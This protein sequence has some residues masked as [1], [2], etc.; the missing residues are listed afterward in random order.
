MPAH[1][2]TAR[3]IFLALIAAAV[4]AAPAAGRPAR[5]GAVPGQLVF[6]IVGKVSYSDDFGDARWQGGHEGNDI[7]AERKAPVVAV[8]AGR[9]AFW[10]RSSSA[11]C[12]L[13]L[14]GRS[15][16]MLPLHPPEQRPDDAERQPRLVRPRRLVRARP[17]RRAER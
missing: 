11:G 10:T 14:Y 17:R 9:V 2:L 4:L 8:E 3:S 1:R 5:A 13:Y 7:V 16:T 12:M 15:G 6:P